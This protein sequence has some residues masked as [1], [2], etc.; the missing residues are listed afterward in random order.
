MMENGHPDELDL[1]AHVDEGPHTPRDREVAAHVRSC[2]DCAE[3]VAEL[4]AGRAALRA[5]PRLELSAA[6][7]TAISEAL[8]QHRPAH[9]SYVSPMRLA[10][11]LAPVAVVAA[12]V[13]LADSVRDSGG[14]EAGRDAAAPA[15]VQR[16]RGDEAEEGAADGGAQ[17]G[18]AEGEAPG[19]GADSSAG[20]GDAL[21]AAG[22]VANV[23][24]PPA[25]VL[26]L[27][28]DA[29]LTARLSGGRVVVSGAT[30]DEVLDALGERR[31]GRVPVVLE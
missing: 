7:R 24:G 18:A 27:L 15:E 9:R 11:V 6:R 2:R 23:A 14:D 16:A 1:L 4:Q 13:V 30:A 20:G 8:A 10:T 19:S 17:G 28:R 25:D 21:S 26:R 29:G 5:A 3:T 22:P 31:R 12:A